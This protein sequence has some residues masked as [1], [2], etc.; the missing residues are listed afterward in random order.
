MATST[1]KMAGG[2]G[3]S[4]CVTDAPSTG[5]WSSVPP[6]GPSKNATQLLSILAQ[7]AGTAL[8]HAAKHDRDYGDA[9]QLTKSIADLKAANRELAAMVARLQRQTKVHEA[10]STALAAGTGEQGIADALND[11]TGHSFI[12]LL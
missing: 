10:L 1:S 12:I 6:A 9:A 5:A 8:A 4:R 3:R 7:Q 2:G 11:L